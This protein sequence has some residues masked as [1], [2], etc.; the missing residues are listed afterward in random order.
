MR[1]S[2]LK[3]SGD[4]HVIIPGVNGGMVYIK[5]CVLARQVVARKERKKA[6]GGGKSD[7]IVNALSI[8]NSR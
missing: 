8:Q 1:E 2:I 7:H 5:R 6:Q 3:V 4:D